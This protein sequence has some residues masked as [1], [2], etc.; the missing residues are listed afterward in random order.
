M[1]IPAEIRTVLRPKNTI[2]DDSDR[3]GPKRYS[4]KEHSYTKY[5]A[6]G[7]PQPY[8]GKV[9]GHIIDFQYVATNGYSKRTQAEPDML[10][11]GESALVRSVTK[12]LKEAL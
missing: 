5:V 10:S 1:S 2:V 3:E 12:N 11:Y 4:V 8:N 9:I 6:S 7:N